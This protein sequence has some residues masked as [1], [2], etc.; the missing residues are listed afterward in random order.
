M[1]FLLIFAEAGSPIAGDLC[2]FEVLMKSFS[3]KDKTLRK[4]A[5]IVHET[6][7]EGRQIQNF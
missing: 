3:L 6:G 5:E 2:T 1:L 7:S 4:I